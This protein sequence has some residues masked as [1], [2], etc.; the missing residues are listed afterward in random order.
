MRFEEQYLQLMS[1]TINDFR[2]LDY[3]PIE[4]RINYPVAK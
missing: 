3:A 2:V 4:P 1:A